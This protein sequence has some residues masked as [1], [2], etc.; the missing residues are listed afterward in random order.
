[1]INNLEINWKVIDGSFDLL[2]LDSGRGQ[3]CTLKRRRR[4]RT[5]VVVVSVGLIHENWAVGFHFK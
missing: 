1:M 3:R 2:P 5:Q 4:R